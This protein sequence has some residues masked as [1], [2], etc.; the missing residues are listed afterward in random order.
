M[1]KILKFNLRKR[2]SKRYLEWLAN[3][4]RHNEGHHVVGKRNDYL[5]A[6]ISS[7]EHKKVHHCTKDSTPFELLMVNAL[8]NLFDYIEHLESI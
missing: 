8:E 5:I 7:E 3:K 1:D 4:D 2:E 6:K